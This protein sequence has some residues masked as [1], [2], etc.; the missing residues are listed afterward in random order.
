[1]MI[2]YCEEHVYCQQMSNPLRVL[3]QETGDEAISLHQLTGERF[4]EPFIKSQHSELRLKRL[5]RGCS[6][7]KPNNY[8]KHFGLRLAMTAER[9]EVT[10]VVETDI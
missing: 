8:I 5:L 3:V 2:R 1:M 6:H 4:L 7:A 9:N 10:N